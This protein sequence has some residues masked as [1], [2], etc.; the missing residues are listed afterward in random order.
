MTRRGYQIISGC[1]AALMVAAVIAPSPPAA[2]GEAS[3]DPHA[4]SVEVLDGRFEIPR[5]TAM[6][7]VPPD[8]A[9]V[10]VLRS[11]TD[12]R[13]QIDV[14]VSDSVPER[15]WERYWRAFDNQLR[16]AGFVV[17]NSRQR[18]SHADQ[19][20]WWFDYELEEDDETYNLLV[21]HTHR[22]E[23]AWV[24]SAFFREPRRDAHERTFLEL[25]DALEW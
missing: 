9:A 6:V 7:F 15:R 16:D 22:G 21:W 25:L 5:P 2:G 20:G 23:H 24:F 11:E 1:I 18:R 19:P 3:V 12:T 8:D 4:D 13:A 17:R 14:R 10:A